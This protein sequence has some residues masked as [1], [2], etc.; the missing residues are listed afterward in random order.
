MGTVSILEVFVRRVCCTSIV[1]GTSHALFVCTHGVG[2]MYLCHPRPPLLPLPLLLLFQQFS[3]VF[4][5]LIVL[6]ENKV[7]NLLTVGFLWRDKSTTSF[8]ACFR[9]FGLVS[10]RNTT[11][12]SS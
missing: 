3:S 7:S 2:H 5:S 1:C 9:V 11:G 12:L 10:L 6:A 4:T 8:S